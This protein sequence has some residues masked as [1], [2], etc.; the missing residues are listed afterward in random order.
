MK[1]T[2]RANS[3]ESGGIEDSFK[4]QLAELKAKK[5]ELV[6]ETEPY[7]VDSSDDKWYF[8]V[9]RTYDVTL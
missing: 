9:R 6:D 3:S 1:I 5:V 4:S 7:R 2:L 8:E